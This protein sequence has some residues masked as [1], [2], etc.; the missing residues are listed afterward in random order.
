MTLVEALRIALRGL[1][2]NALRTALTALGIII[3]ISAVVI[4]VA[5]GNGAERYIRDQ[6]E[7]LGSNLLLVTPGNVKQGGVNLGQGAAVT[8][9]LDDARLVA[10]QAPAVRAVSPVVSTRGTASFLNQNTVTN[11]VGVMPAYL[12]VRNFEV[13][14]GRFILPND[15]DGASKIAVL[16]AGVAADLFNG[17]A[18]GMIGKTVK[19]NQQ[20]FEV[21]G[22]LK[23]KGGAGFLNQ[24]DQ[25]VIPITTAQRRLF[26]N[27]LDNISQMVVQA[28]TQDQMEEAAI[29]TAAILR[30]R[31]HLPP[32]RPDDFTIQS[33]NDVL[34]TASS[35]AKAMT[36]LLGAIAS[37]SLLV[38]G[39]GIMNIMLVSVT[40]R[41]REI[42]I[43]RAVGAQRR[44]ILAQFV[45]EAVVL[46]GLGGVGGSLLGISLAK[47]FGSLSVA[48]LSLT[49]IV[50]AS[51]VLMALGVSVAI[52]LFF[53]IYPARRASR[54]NPIDALR[55]E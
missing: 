52:G 24:D 1:Q 51:S 13:S 48:G 42:G 10:Q 49:P 34:N 19:L 20:A 50:D 44:D 15:V 47:L 46:C 31:H 16:G 9:T 43:R 41:T 33:Q 35:L 32:S 26:R 8:L 53:G 29:Q 7:V 40:E 21:V 11:L 14:Q 55:Y 18:E 54:L 45:V 37:I 2:T 27:A 12:T 6:I 38:G 17:A 25:V 4:M 3:G 28:V 36:I 23:P 22:V 39:I 5:L 30:L